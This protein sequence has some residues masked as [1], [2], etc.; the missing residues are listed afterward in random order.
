MGR[1]LEIQPGD[2]GYKKTTLYFTIEELSELRKL[3][4]ETGLTV[5]AILREAWKLAGPELAAE[6]PDIKAL[7][8]PE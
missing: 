1:R 5:S 6:A 3:A 2:P 8:V 7:T 4:E